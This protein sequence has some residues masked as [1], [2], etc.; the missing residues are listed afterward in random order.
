MTVRVQAVFGRQLRTSLSHAG[1]KRV[2]NAEMVARRDA[3]ARFKLCRRS[4][5]TG[6]WDKCLQAG[7][8]HQGCDDFLTWWQR[9]VR[10]RLVRRT[11]ASYTG[12]MQEMQPKYRR[13]LGAK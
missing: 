3:T 1:E 4:R 6:K 5:R 7:P 10:W 11:D 12:S 2:E 13:K 8:T 9:A